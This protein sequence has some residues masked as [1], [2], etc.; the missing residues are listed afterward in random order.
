MGIAASVMAVA[1][2]LTGFAPNFLGTVAPGP[3]LIGAGGGPCDSSGEDSHRII[4]RLSKDA[5]GRHHFCPQCRH[6]PNTRPCADLGRRPRL[7]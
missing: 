3:M 2:V 6:F 5:R 7:R 4:R 1:W